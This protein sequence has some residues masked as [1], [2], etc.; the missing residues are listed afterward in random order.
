M[1][2]ILKS[3]RFCEY[4]NLLVNQ[5]TIIKSVIEKYG[6]CDTFELENT[7]DTQLIHKIAEVF[8]TKII[9][10]SLLLYGISIFSETLPQV[11][12]KTNKSENTLPHFKTRT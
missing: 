8:D 2:M 12:K 5:E 3:N 4:I 9:N 11:L 10:P 7:T 6:D 1:E